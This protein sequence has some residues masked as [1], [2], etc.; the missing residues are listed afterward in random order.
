MKQGIAWVILSRWFHRFKARL[1]YRLMYS[2]EDTS[3]EIK[4]RIFMTLI[5][6]EL[7]VSR[8]VLMLRKLD[9]RKQTKISPGE[10]WKYQLQELWRETTQGYQTHDDTA[11]GFGFF[12]PHNK[13]DLWHLELFNCKRLV[14]CSRWSGVRLKDEYSLKKN[15]AEVWQGLNRVPE[16][17]VAVFWGQNRQEFLYFQCR[18][19]ASVMGMKDIK[20]S[21][22]LFSFP[23]TGYTWTWLVPCSCFPK[24]FK[25][26]S[27]RDLRLFC[28]YLPLSPES[29]P[30]PLLPEHER[31]I[32]QN[33]QA[34]R[35]ENRI[36]ARRSQKRLLCRLSLFIMTLNSSACSHN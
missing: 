10:C 6:I 16:D 36:R 33:D 12:S 14:G 28:A 25:S 4:R 24:F 11:L 18:R 30:Y 5:W 13:Y 22:N 7:R 32:R 15:R 20:N 8:E 19:D 27:N 3:C 2:G 21:F 23:Q 9:F 35:L 29:C 26:S 17:V 34:D 31:G 1:H